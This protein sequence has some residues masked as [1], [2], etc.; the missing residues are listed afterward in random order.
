MRIINAPSAYAVFWWM[1]GNEQVYR[2]W[3]SVVTVPDGYWHTYAIPLHSNSAWQS[4]GPIR[5]FQFAPILS[6]GQIELASLELVGP[7]P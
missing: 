5:R 1:D 7:V 2:K 4:S 6:S 3:A